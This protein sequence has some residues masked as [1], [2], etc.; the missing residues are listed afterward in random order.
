MNK[1]LVY[2][3]L[4][5]LL[6]TVTMVA[7]LALIEQPCPVPEKFVVS[8]VDEGSLQ[9]GDMLEAPEATLGQKDYETFGDS[10]APEDVEAC[11]TNLAL[12][13]ASS[14]LSSVGLMIV[15]SFLV[16]LGVFVYLKK[17]VE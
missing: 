15:P 3:A 8:D 13:D 2:T 5:I 14:G 12:V 11:E 17:R 1:F 10:P 4:A 6:G 16:A 9:R 7:P